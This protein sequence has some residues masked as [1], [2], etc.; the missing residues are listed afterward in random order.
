MKVVSCP[1]CHKKNGFLAFRN[2]QRGKKKY[3]YVCHYDPTKYE[4]Q[5]KDYL[6]GKRKSKPT[7][8]KCCSITLFNATCLDFAEDWFPEYLNII[9]KIHRNYL[10]YGFMNENELRRFCKKIP[11]MFRLEKT[12]KEFVKNKHWKKD[13]TLAEKFLKN[14]GY[15][16]YLARTKIM[17]DIFFRFELGRKH[18]NG[19]KHQLLYMV[20]LD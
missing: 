17:K 11:Y 19:Y 8:R 2:V 12:R 4:E 9:K 20:F 7:G 16:A 14:A 6:S 10:R 18:R 5:M 3:P 15:S 13:W 1:N